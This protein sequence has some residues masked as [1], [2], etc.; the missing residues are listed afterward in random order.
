MSRSG[1]VLGF[2]DGR[3]RSK[4]VAAGAVFAAAGGI[5]GGLT[6][7]WLAEYFVDLQYDRA[8]LRVGPF[9]WNNWHITFLLSALARA[10]SFLWVVRMPDPGAKRFRDV[11]R[12]VG[13]NIYNNAL[14]RMLRRPLWFR[15]RRGSGTRR[16][17]L[18]IRRLL[19]RRRRDRAA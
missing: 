11:V 4:Y 12:H 5:L 7:G 18:S 10:L 14:P 19:R 1:I 2:S 17:S 13:V 15:R 3:G 16:F 9:L 8:P 6:G